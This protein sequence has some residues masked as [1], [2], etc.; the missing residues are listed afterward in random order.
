MTFQ[1]ETKVSFEKKKRGCSSLGKLEPGSVFFLTSLCATMFLY[2]NNLL[3]AL[4]ALSPF[5]FEIQESS[6]TARY[7]HHKKE[8]QPR[9]CLLGMQVVEQEIELKEC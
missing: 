8:S 4:L 5:C 7:A 2:F 3:A 9:Q 1:I 6:L